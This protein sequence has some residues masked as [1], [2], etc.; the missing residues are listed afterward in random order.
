[1]NGNGL[2]DDP[3]YLIP[4]SRGLSYAGG[5]VPTI[6]EPAGAGNEEVGEELYL[7]GA[8]ANPNW[9]DG[10]TAND[11]TEFNWGYA[12]LNPT[13]APVDDNYVRPDD[14]RTVGVTPGSGGGDAFDIAW[15]IDASGALANRASFDFIRLTTLVDRNLQSVGEASSEVNAVAD[16]A[17]VVGEEEPEVKTVPLDGAALLFL[18]LIVAGA[19]RLGR[20]DPL[21]EKRRNRG[22]TLIELLVVIAI[23]SILAALLLPALGRAREKALSM[24]CVN[25]L[26]QLY[27]ANSMYADESRGR[28][29]PAA[30]D[31][32][33][34]GGGLHRWHGVR[35]RFDLEF[36]GRKGPLAEYL[37]DER[38]KACPVFTEFLERGDMDNAFESGTGG[39]GYNRS[40]IGGTAHLNTYPTS[41]RMTML[42]SRVSSPSKTIMFA[43][44]ALPQDGYLIEYGFLEAPHFPNPDQPRG[45]P[46]FGF[47]A[48]SIHFRHYRRANVLWADG[49]VTS[50]RWEWAPEKN[51]YQGK[52]R[53]WSVG[54]FGPRNNY[55]FDSGD[56]SA[57]SIKAK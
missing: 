9:L 3:W 22:F 21:S 31:I 30:P 16:V 41:N 2:A 40:Y 47:A 14:P 56:K 52:N 5:V 33:Q 15:A 48:P 19:V 55:Y 13:L 50:E 39:Y 42:D 12:E 49:H 29:A 1:V 57:Y 53:S 45:N 51:V 38:V 4:G 6:V 46:D 20:S 32:D 17:P 44:S 25:N 11:E 43:D 18:I 10:D 37:V 7:A 24:Q 27:L 34:A 36:D 26:R 8:I 28:Y 23:I 35:E 54:W